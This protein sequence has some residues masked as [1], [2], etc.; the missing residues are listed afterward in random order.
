MTVSAR[1]LST[2]GGN[3]GS[4]HA[5]ALTAALRSGVPP[6]S[7]D[8]KR[9]RTQESVTF[10]RYRAASLDGWSVSVVDKVHVVDECPSC[11]ERHRLHE[12]ATPVGDLDDRCTREVTYVCPETGH[13]VTAR[14]RARSAV[15]SYDDP[16]GGT[17]HVERPREMREDWRPTPQAIARSLTT[18]SRNF[19]VRKGSEGF[20]SVP[21]RCNRAVCAICGSYKAA[22][23]VAREVPMYGALARRGYKLVHCTFTARNDQFKGQRLPTEGAEYA[24]V[25][26]EALG[27]AWERQTHTVKRLRDSRRTREWWKSAVLAGTLGTE[28]TGRHPR[29]HFKR[30]H[31][32]T[33]ALLALRSGVL[34]DAV[35]ETD[36]STGRR[37][38]VGGSFIERLRE[39]WCSIADADPAGLHLSLVDGTDDD[40]LQSGVEEVVKYPYKQGDLTVPQLLEIESTTKGLKPHQVFGALHGSSTYA[41]AAKDE[42]L[43]D[44]LGAVDQ[45]VVDAIREGRAEV[46]RLEE[47][48]ATVQ[49]V[50]WSTVDDLRAEDPDQDEEE[51][52]LTRH[53][54]T[55]GVWVPCSFRRLLSRYEQGRD[56]VWLG[57]EG[58]ERPIRADLHEFMAELSG[59]QRPEGRTD[60]TDET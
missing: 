48:A 11:G 42:E 31:V 7:T 3:L 4:A 15:L 28:V 19:M 44:E 14:A 20:S 26:G 39:E 52:E 41:K 32:H 36:P 59:V 57:W 56:H 47:E 37:S 13:Q 5:L 38:V 8:R 29:T 43:Y 53:N 25:S 21:C 33:H 54:H 58:L 55:L 6:L 46:E 34:D 60:G 24:A 40:A 45:E 35:V 16:E 27:D 17:L 10:N 18:C 12:E 50:Q 9:V 1:P 51:H 22:A 23:R 30:W 2:P 49:V